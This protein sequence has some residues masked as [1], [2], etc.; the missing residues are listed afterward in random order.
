MSSE[1][2]A[3]SPDQEELLRELLDAGLLIETGTPGLYGHGETFERLRVRLAAVISALARSGGAVN[4]TFPPVIPRSNLETTGYVG[5]FPQLAGSIFE[6]DGSE[7]DARVQRERAAAHE[8]WSEF[9]SQTDLMMLPAACY[10]VYPAVAARGPLSA[11]GVF[12]DMGGTWVFRREPS[13]DPARRQA[14]RQHELVR[15]GE[16]DTVIAWRSEWAQRGVGLLTRLGL[17]ARLE[18]ASDPFFG[19]HGRLLAANQSAEELKW[20]LVVPIAGP[21]PTACASFNYHIDRFGETWGLKLTDGTT[22]HTACCGFGQERIVLA[23]LRT[24]GLDPERWP[25]EVRAALEPNVNSNPESAGNTPPETTAA[26][27]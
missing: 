26:A 4:V 6:F 8:D 22:A 20:E 3:A 15:I 11:G 24:H 18:I 17:D 27:W 12:V 2:R 10:P 25:A 7:A 16:P 13:L 19:R 21:E 5:N 14:F 1:L 23:L 9:Q